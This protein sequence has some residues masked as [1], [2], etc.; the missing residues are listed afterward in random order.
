MGKELNT[1]PKWI[2]KLLHRICHEELIDSVVGDL[3]QLFQKHKDKYGG[4]T[5]SFLYLFNVLQFLQ[6][7]SFRSPNFYR[8][9]YQTYLQVIFRS[10]KKKKLITAMNLSGMTLSIVVFLYIFSYL[11][12]ELSFDQYHK[13]ADRVYRVTYRYQNADGYDIHWARMSQSWVN[14]LPNSFSM[15]E[16]LVRFQSFRTRDVK[17]GND[18]FRENFSYDVDPGVFQL[19]DLQIIEGDKSPLDNPYS[20]VL[21][22]KAAEKYFGSKTPIGELIEIT[23]DLG[24]SEKYTVTALIE[25]P[26]SN[27][28]L[29]IHLLTSI[30]DEKDRTGWAYTYVLLKTGGSL[31]SIESGISEFLNT[32][33]PLNEGD[34]ISLHFQPLSS[35]H[36]QSHLSREIIPNG[37]INQLI[38][39]GC[40]GI[41]LILIASVNFINL[42]AIQSLD[43][44]K[45]FGLRKYL[46]ASKNELKTYFKLEALLLGLFS[47]MLAFGVF[48]FGLD[49]FQQFI[50]QVLEFSFYHM[51]IAIVAIL[52]MLMILSAVSSG[53]LL[54]KSNFSQI[55]NWFSTSVGYNG[56]QKRVLLVIQ[57]CMVLMLISSM[58]IVK[59]QFTYMTEKNLGYNQ[60][61]L[62]ILKNNNR[63]VMAQYELLKSE[64]KSISGIEDVSAIM[65][66]P[67][68]AVKDQGQVTILEDPELTISA[69]IQIVDMNLIDVMELEL[70]SGESIPIHLRESKIEVDSILWEKFTSK[71]RGY[72]INESACKLLGYAPDEALG[73]NINWTIGGFSL[74]HGPIYGV[75]KN[76]HQES[77]IEKIRPVIMTYEPLWLR[78]ILVKAKGQELFDLH[79]RIEGYWKNRFPNQALEI[80]YLDQEVEKLYQSE[81]KQ[82]QLISFFTGIAI[83]IGFMGLYAMMAYTI[84]V[85]IKE[86]A[87][88]RVLGS[89]FIDQLKLLGKE[90]LILAIL[91]MCVVFPLTYGIMN[92]WLTNYAYHISID[93]I[94]FGLAAMLLIGI[95]ISTLIFQIIQF[96]KMNPNLALKTE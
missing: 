95:I 19:F 36:L 93:G 31:E 91:A 50:G 81:K 84:K 14:E 33:E 51:A 49:F 3:F 61:Q 59:Q 83:I 55:V 77:L 23:N 15:I 69:D 82:L 21:T 90:Y 66:M 7:F 16:E 18:N 86:L 65:E 42:N 78:H 92:H 64:L 46:G 32:H 72:L 6:P 57:F 34:K 8:S 26:P 88:R 37:N 28:H 17:V 45:E 85:R 56:L 80:S 25:N 73:K 67:S 70:V 39:F 10:V 30:N 62:L 22:Q 75:I 44:L 40:V 48:L 87:I 41:F 54:S 71:E 43:R 53:L 74:N 47:S 5:A 38:I 94:S 11:S 52:I 9:I 29:P 58:Y 76:Y 13:N 89:D 27:T 63:T 68:V 24:I 1:P 96:G 20:V 4:F 60:N 79:Q 12:H 35:I 2:T